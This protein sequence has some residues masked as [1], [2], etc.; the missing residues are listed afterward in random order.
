MDLRESADDRAFRDEVRTFLEDSL[1]G[2]FAAV[3]GRG[4]PGDEHAC[5]EKRQA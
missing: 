1:S 2:E 3:R 4:G 5:Y